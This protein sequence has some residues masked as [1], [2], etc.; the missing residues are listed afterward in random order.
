MPTPTPN[1]VAM[2][3]TER[4]DARAFSIRDTTLEAVRGAPSRTPFARAVAG[5]IRKCLAN[6]MLTRAAG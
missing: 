5:Q 3:R 2:A 6:T 1:L 4:P